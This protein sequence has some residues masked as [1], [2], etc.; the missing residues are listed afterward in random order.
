MLP[1]YA[2]VCA[3]APPKVGLDNGMWAFP[4]WKGPKLLEGFLKDMGINGTILLAKKLPVDPIVT[5]GI[6]YENGSDVVWV[7]NG[8]WAIPPMGTE[9]EGSGCW[10]IEGIGCSIAIDIGCWVVAL[11]P[12]IAATEVTIGG[13]LCEA[14]PMAIWSK[15]NVLTV[16]TFWSKSLK[17]FKSGYGSPT[18]GEL[19]GAWT[20]MGV[21][22]VST[23]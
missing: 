16:L 4:N 13:M 10:A 23:G 21:S 2:L 15:G 17:L 9:V 18:K 8:Y 11:D 7:C 20:C 1:T 5:G 3:K 12:T 14:F 6:P 19:R 22:C